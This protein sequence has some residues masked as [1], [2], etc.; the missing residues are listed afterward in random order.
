MEDENRGNLSG[1]RSAS[2]HGNYNTSVAVDS[3]D[4][5]GEVT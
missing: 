1:S 3:G 4:G 2:H 5:M